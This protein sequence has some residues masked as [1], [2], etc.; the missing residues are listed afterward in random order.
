MIWTSITEKT[1]RTITDAKVDIT[2]HEYSRH[3]LSC[4]MKKVQNSATYSQTLLQAE[5]D[6]LITASLW[7]YLLLVESNMCTRHIYGKTSCVFLMA[8]FYKAQR[9]IVLK[10]TKAKRGFAVLWAMRCPMGTIYSALRWANGGILC[11]G[12][13]SAGMR[14]GSIL[15]SHLLSRPIRLTQQTDSAAQQTGPH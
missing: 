11:G 9:D 14:Q 13:I 4:Y 1:H 15:A 10:Q 6:L 7:Q 5:K 2:L 3:I 8:R 12:H